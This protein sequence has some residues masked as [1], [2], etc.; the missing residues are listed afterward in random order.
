VALESSAG[1][2]RFDIRFEVCTGVEAQ[3][4]RQFVVTTSRG[5]V[6]LEPLALSYA[7]AFGMC[8]VFASDI[9]TPAARIE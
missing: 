5:T 4:L 1:D 7:A 2:R 6:T 9:R 3:G 8:S